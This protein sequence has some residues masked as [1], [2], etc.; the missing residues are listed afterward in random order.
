MFRFVRVSFLAIAAVTAVASPALYSATGQAMAEPRVSKEAVQA[1]KLALKGDFTAAGQAAQRS[2]DGAAIK[3]V[4]LLY[5]RKHPNDAGYRRIMDFIDAAPN[6][7][8]SITL[9]KRAELSLYINKEP[10]SLVMAHFAKRKPVMPEG[11]LAL[12]RAL[13]ANG[14]KAGARQHVRNV[15]LNGDISAA[16][17]KSVA[18]EFGS[19]LSEDDHEKRMWQLVYSQETNAAIRASKRLSR[20]YQKAAKVAQI[21]IR[22]KAGADKQ[23]AALPK[24]MRNQ[25]GM[26]YALT[27]FYRRK[28]NYSKA[29]SILASIPGDPAVMGDPQAW[30]VER[31]IIARHSVGMANRDHAKAAYTISRAHGFTKGS[32]ALEG[33][34]LAGW[35]ALRYLKDP[36]T[37]LKHFQRLGQIADTRTEKGAR[38]LLVRPGARGHGAQGG[39]QGPIS[40]GVAIFH[41]L[42]RPARPRE[43][44]ARKRARRNLRWHALRRGK[45]QDRQG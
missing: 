5:L 4:E 10:P 26:K 39:C 8:L 32:G 11:S 21:L 45:G 2:G 13:L 22:S 24:A 1:A 40:S 9:T 37:S 34:F 14:D 30:W 19:L 20:D 36:G 27:R 41:H 25:L 35:I 16:L 23:Y 33:E 3:L 31:R 38:G 28:A 18:Q 17:E 29:R 44:R 12:A 15:W 43:D 7:P 6:W 42:L